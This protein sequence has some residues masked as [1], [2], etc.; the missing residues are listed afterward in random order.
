MTQEG[1]HTQVRIVKVRVYEKG[2][3]E[4]IVVTAMLQT[5]YNYS[6]LKDYYR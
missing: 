1:V 6:S 5:I 2:R 3:Q 4:L